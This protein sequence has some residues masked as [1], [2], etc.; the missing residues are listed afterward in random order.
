MVGVNWDN[1][2]D[3]GYEKKECKK[4]KKKKKTGYL[5]QCGVDKRPATRMA[6][7]R[8]Q[9]TGADTMKLRVPRVVRQPFAQEVQ[10]K[11]PF[12]RSTAH[13]AP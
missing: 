1:E 11:L 4:K 10:R 5:V 12:P 2:D 9:G 3:D 7:K 8:E 6:L 13:S